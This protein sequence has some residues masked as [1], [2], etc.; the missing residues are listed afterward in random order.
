VNLKD[1]TDDFAKREQSMNRWI[2]LA[3]WLIPAVAFVHACGGNAT[4]DSTSGNTNWL[5]LCDKQADCGEGLSC[6][7]NT[8]QE[9]C[10]ENTDCD[11]AGSGSRCAAPSDEMQCSDAPAGVRLCVKN[12]DVSLDCE[13]AD[14]TCHDGYCA[15]RT[16]L[17]AGADDASAPPNDGDSNETL[18]DA[19]ISEPPDAEVRVP[20]ATG[21]CGCPATG[22]TG[23]SGFGIAY[24]LVDDTEPTHPLA[25]RAN[26]DVTFDGSGGLSTYSVGNESI[27][28]G[29]AFPDPLPS[30]FGN[31]VLWGN[32]IGGSASRTVG[33]VETPL[34]FDANEGFHY[35]LGK[36][37]TQLPEGLAVYEQWDGTDPSLSEG[38]E[39]VALSYVQVA[40]DSF[41]QKV[42]LELR[43]TLEGYSPMTFETE[44]GIV[45][46]SATQGVLVNRQFSITMGGSNALRVKG[47]VVDDGDAIALS[48]RVD[49]DEFNA[50]AGVPDAGPTSTRE[51]FGAAGI[52]RT[53]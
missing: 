7:C 19:T 6:L 50:P 26:C 38:S 47:I 28:I 30:S 40:I 45:D 22:F 20:D 41:T 37:A 39:M 31:S 51:I 2:R 35:A 5:K 15:A 13:R 36:V 17:D 46:I 1:E 10:S 42:G 23:G 29:A 25:T 4:T 24:V 18:P 14:L 33:G 8:C 44:G 11:L 53:Q 43:V 12:C 9:T 32:W 16:V 21:E 52:L 27:S 49:V 48:Y 34:G 3:A